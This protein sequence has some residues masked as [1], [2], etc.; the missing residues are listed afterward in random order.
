MLARRPNDFIDSACF[1]SAL[2]EIKIGGK[3]GTVATGCDDGASDDDHSRAGNNSLFNR[4]FEADVGVT[5]AFGSKIA[6]G[7]KSGQQSV[8]R[9]CGGCGGAEGEGFV[10]DLV[11]PGRFVIGMEKEMGVTFDQPGNKSV[12]RQIDRLSVVRRADLGCRA[13]FFDPLP[14]H[15]D[16]PARMQF[17]SVK[18]RSRPKKISASRFGLGRARHE[19]D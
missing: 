15:Q 3:L 11:V 6:H 17:S 12:V 1:L 2:G 4:L 19:A 9:V 7:R 13:S 10:S 5:R 14:S 18:N 16:R 8:P